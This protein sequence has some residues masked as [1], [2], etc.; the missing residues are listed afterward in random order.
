MD[1]LWVDILGLAFLVV[2]GGFFAGAET[3]LTAASRARMH[4]LEND[5][6]A[7]ARL[8]NKLRERKDSMIGALLFGNTLVQIMSGALAT[9][10]FIHFFGK[11]G[12]AYA[13]VVDTAIIL[14]FAEVL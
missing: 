12:V 7:R 1:S 2:C 5:G 8:V 3:A 6:N 9:A 13:T 14:V 10:M 4:T 11:A